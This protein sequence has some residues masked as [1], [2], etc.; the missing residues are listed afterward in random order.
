MNAIDPALGDALGADAAE[1]SDQHFIRMAGDEW[2]YG[3]LD[4][5]SDRVAAGL[6]V[7]GVRL[8]DAPSLGVQPV[9]EALAGYRVP[10]AAA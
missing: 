4:A 10:V 7:L 1:A 8:S 3:W 6:H 9:L 5:E 2:R